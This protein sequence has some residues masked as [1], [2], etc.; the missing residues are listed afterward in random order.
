M[1]KTVAQ[2]IMD[3]ATKTFRQLLR[4]SKVSDVYPNINYEKNKND[5]FLKWHMEKI[6][7]L[8]NTIYNNYP[9]KHLSVGI[10]FK[11]E[12]AS[13]RSLF[14]FTTSYSPYDTFGQVIMNQR[15]DIPLIFKIVDNNNEISFYKTPFVLLCY[16]GIDILSYLMR[17]CPNN[18]KLEMFNENI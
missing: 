10:F 14:R 13:E 7:D 11:G 18:T 8:C 1:S 15:F 17:L 12:S 5:L 9:I 6:K 2:Q 3:D 16:E 4:D